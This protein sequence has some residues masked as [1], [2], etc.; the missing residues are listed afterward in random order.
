MG[1]SNA[2]A[3]LKIAVAA[4]Q[5]HRLRFFDAHSVVELHHVMSQGRVQY[6]TCARETPRSLK[7]NPPTHLRATK[8]L[9]PRPT[10][11]KRLKN[12]PS[13]LVLTRTRT[14]RSLRT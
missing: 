6:Q 10:T 14:R 1:V 8:A 5:R 2:E 7:M 12:A 9:T 4:T 3:E 13:H 11:S